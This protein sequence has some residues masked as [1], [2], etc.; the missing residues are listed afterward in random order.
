M[1]II[2]IASILFGAMASISPGETVLWLTVL[3]FAT[4]FAFGDRAA[5]GLPILH[6]VLPVSVVLP[7]PVP[8]VYERPDLQMPSYDLMGSSIGLL[9]QSSC[10]T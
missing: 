9:Y 8:V 6:G 3:V 5:A 7:A 1:G 2:A 4:A 10:S